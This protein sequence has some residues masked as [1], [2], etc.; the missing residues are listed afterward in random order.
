MR[1]GEP[2]GAGHARW[3]TTMLRLRQA[4]SADVLELKELLEISVRRL[5]TGDYTPAQIEAA[6]QTL[7]GIDTQ[8]IADGT[9]YL[10][11]YHATTEDKAPSSTIVG[12]GGW[13]KRRTLFGGDQYAGRH[14]DL[15]DP[16][17][18]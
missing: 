1:K 6:L 9:Y 3:Q 15:L 13:S 5:Q 14:D 7:Y 10:A 8:L 12:C 18:D 4:T 17:R 2:R 16:R 11:E